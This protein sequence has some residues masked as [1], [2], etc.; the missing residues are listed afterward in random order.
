M[1]TETIENIDQL[2]KETLR[3]FN[4]T[5]T[6]WWFR[7]QRNIDWPLLP[8]VKRGYKDEE[9]YLTNLFY[10]RARTRYANYPGNDD[11]GG[12]LALMQHYGLPTRLL[13]WSHSPLV[14]AYFATKFPFDMDTNDTNPTD[15][16]VWALE[17]HELNGAQGYERVYPPLNANSL[18][19]IVRPAR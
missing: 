15:A 1:K 14:A 9:R 7:G 13:D 10:A 6:R 3:I 11:D 4:S 19:E 17:P 12:W 8:G 16:I 5:R 18:K 2:T